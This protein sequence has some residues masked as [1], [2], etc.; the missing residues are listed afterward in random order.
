[1]QTPNSLLAESIIVVDTPE[2]YMRLAEENGYPIFTLDLQEGT[3]GKW[4][5]PLNID[6]KGNE[7]VPI[8]LDERVRQLG[9]DSMKEAYEIIETINMDNPAEFKRLCEWFASDKTKDGLLA[10]KTTPF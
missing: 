4:I 1:M 3:P 10:C 9:F 7:I 8:P 2:E 6:E 5:N